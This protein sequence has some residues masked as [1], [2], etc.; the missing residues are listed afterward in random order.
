MRKYHYVDPNEYVYLRSWSEAYGMFHNI[1]G[2]N[3]FSWRKKTKDNKIYYY[4]DES[5]I[6]QLTDDDLKINMAIYQEYQ[7]PTYTVIVQKFD[8][9][10]ELHT[11]IEIRKYFQKNI[12][13]GF[14]EYQ[15]WH[16]LQFWG[17]RTI[18]D[19]QNE[20]DSMTTAIPKQKEQAEERAKQIVIQEQE[21]HQLKLEQEQ[22]QREAQK[23][24]VDKEQI[25]QSFR[26]TPVVR[27]Y[28]ETLQTKIRQLEDRV[29][30]LDAYNKEIQ[31]NAN[32]LRS[33]KTEVQEEN[34]R[35]ESK[36]LSLERKL[37]LLL[38]RGF[39]ERM[40]QKH[41]ANVSDLMTQL[42]NMSEMEDN[43]LHANHP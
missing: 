17:D 8:I 26:D 13:K 9:T 16:D 27:E 10:G 36:I 35:L 38:N 15:E 40:I 39:Y 41:E 1:D 5:E 34:A 12:K 24:I 31:E 18:E 30:H 22:R 43:K 19:A 14:T 7:N 2:Y 21:R 32:K 23:R 28:L 33:D 6:R 20:L 37:K 3:N 4:Q 29:V 11:L 42:K 25:L